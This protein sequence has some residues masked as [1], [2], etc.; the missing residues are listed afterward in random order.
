MYAWIWRK[1]PFGLPGKLAG[2]VLLA[3]TVGLLLWYVIFPWATPLLPFDDVQ[4]GTDPAG[5]RWVTVTVTNTGDRRGREVVQV[6]LSRPGS[7]VERPVRWLAGWTVVSA[8]PGAQATADV[9]VGARAF[10]HWDTD[11]HGWATEPGELTVEVAR[12]AGTTDLTTTVEV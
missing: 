8:E 3:A 2:S 7:A 4:V 1:L 5:D 12:H 11:V 6:Y 9:R 10:E